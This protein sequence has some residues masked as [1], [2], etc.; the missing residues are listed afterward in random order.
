M[1]E[2]QKTD[3][4][5]KLELRAA[6]YA[7]KIFTKYSSNIDVLLR[8]DNTTAVSYINRMSGIRVPK[9]NKMARQIWS[10]CGRKNR[11]L[12][13]GYINSGLNTEAYQQSRSHAIETEYEMP[14]CAFQFICDHLGNSEID[15][16][17]TF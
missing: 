15:I 12:F 17:A 7:L 9:L 10:Y 6:F 1:S 4:I 8:F 3:H 11:T 5:N 14:H 2:I 16:F 13:A